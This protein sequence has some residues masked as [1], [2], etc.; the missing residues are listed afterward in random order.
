LNRV[1]KSY[2]ALGIW[3]QPIFDTYGRSIGSKLQDGT[4]TSMGYDNQGRKEYD[5]D[6]LGQRTD[7]GYD[8]L[9][10]IASGIMVT[11]G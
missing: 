8:T 6:V 3:S 5:I 11:I 9:G 7:Y 10:R 2:D 4:F 1:S